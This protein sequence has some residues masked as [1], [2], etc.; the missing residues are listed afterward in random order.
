[1]SFCSLAE[2]GYFGVISYLNQF[3]PRVEKKTKGNNEHPGVKTAPF[4]HKG[5]LPLGD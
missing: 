1:M 4:Y 2:I 3:R 5:Q